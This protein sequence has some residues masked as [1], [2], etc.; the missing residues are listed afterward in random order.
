MSA[1]GKQAKL[2]KFV[3]NVDFD[4]TGERGISVRILPQNENLADPILTNL[5]RWAEPDVVDNG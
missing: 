1:E 4:T 5:V 2:H 3:A